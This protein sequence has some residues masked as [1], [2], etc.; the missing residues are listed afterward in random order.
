MD[1][2]NKQLA[3]KTYICGSEALFNHDL[4]AMLK[5]ETDAFVRVFR[6]Y[7]SIWRVLHIDGFEPR[8]RSIPFHVGIGYQFFQYPSTAKN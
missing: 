3:Y 7:L 1:N 6:G 8:Y 4:V 5:R 2:E